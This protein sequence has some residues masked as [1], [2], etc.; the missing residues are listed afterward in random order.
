MDIHAHDGTRIHVTDWGPSDAPTIVFC[1]AWG[2]SERMWE[3]LTPTFSAAG[4]R[5]VTYDRRGHGRSD[6]ASGGYDLD[7]LADD[8]AVLMDHLDLA[9]AILVGHSLGAAEA[10]RYLT[11]HGAARVAGLVLS[12]PTA[13][14]LAKSPANPQ[15]FDQAFTDA[16]RQ[17]IATDV[18]AMLEATTSDQF[19]GPGHTVSA[20]LSD[21]IRRQI[22]ATP[23]PVLLATFDTN[24]AADLTAELPAITVPTLILQGDLDQSNPVEVT[25]R[26]CAELIPQATMVVFEGTGHGVYR[27]GAA[28]YGD[29]IAAFARTAPRSA[30]E[31]AV[32]P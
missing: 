4:F 7:T 14:G 29:R 26:R 30:R 24:A 15:G 16:V 20:L 11:R 27:S 3:Y 13:P 12:A 17:M 25:G 22:L 9:D 32:V 21:D 28:A 2:V 23:V 6:I 10:I 19:F 31:A 5:C 1:H 18:G 8:I